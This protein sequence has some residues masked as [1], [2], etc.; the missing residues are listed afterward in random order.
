MCLCQI[1]ASEIT[2]VANS[3]PLLV[4]GLERSYSAAALQQ[5]LLVLVELSEGLQLC[6]LTGQGVR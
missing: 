3:P 1:A 6:R 5:H 2:Q 4:A